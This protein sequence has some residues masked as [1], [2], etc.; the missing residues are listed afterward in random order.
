MG[1][2]LINRY[3]AIKSSVA[4]RL[5]PTAEPIADKIGPYWQPISKKYALWTDRSDNSTKT[6]LKSVTGRL[7]SMEL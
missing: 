4:Q 2:M 3:T 7:Y 5:A 6:E 1:P